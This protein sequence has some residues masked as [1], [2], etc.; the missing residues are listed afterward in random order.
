MSTLQEHQAVLLELLEEFDRICKKHAIPYTLFAGSALG[1]VRHGGFIPW[2][3]DLDVA[4]LREHYEHFLK[5]AAVET[6]PEFCLQGEFSDSWP[7][8][9]SKL[10]KNH[11]TCLEKYHPKIQGIHQGIYMD[12]FPMDNAADYEPLRRIQY[13]AARVVH[14][15]TMFRRGYETDSTLKKVFMQLCRLLP[16]K[17]FHDLALQRGKGT[18]RCVHA[19]FGGSIHYAKGIYPREWLC[20]VQPI[21]FESMTVSISRHYDALLR[22]MYGDYMTLPPEED[23]KCKVHAILVD[24]EKNYTEY[25]GYRDGMTFD[26]YTR[27]IR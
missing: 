13:L 8:H 11:T 14:G 17:P 15:K 9:F 6:R 3:D 19:F 7:M 12:I 2:D 27:S 20:E 18:S 25:E 22:A 4:M 26:V 24:T 21:A 16:M 10:R 5:V 1:A 23:R